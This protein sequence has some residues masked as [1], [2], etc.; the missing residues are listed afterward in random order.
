M[1]RK[2]DCKAWLGAVVTF[3]T[4]DSGPGMA[5]SWNESMTND[6]YLNEE[7][8]PGSSCLFCRPISE[9]TNKTHVSFR[10]G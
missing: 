7:C 1:W 4:R 2:Q 10:V 9:H 6:V 8:N 5:R 3:F